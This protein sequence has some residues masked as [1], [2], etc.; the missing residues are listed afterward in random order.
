MIG[1]RD[2]MGVAGQILQHVF[3]PAE[4]FLGI[5]HPV[6]R[7]TECAGTA[8]NAFSFASG[9]QAREKQACLLA[10]GAPQSGHELSAKNAAEYFH[11]QEEAGAR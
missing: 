10:K 2:A 1:D 9:W 6:L 4:G 8:A 3:R 11:R 7:E 5:D